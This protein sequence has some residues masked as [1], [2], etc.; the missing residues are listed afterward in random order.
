MS[1]MK[2]S[3]IDVCLFCI[4]TANTLHTKQPQSL[5]RKDADTAD[6]DTD[7]NLGVT[8][9]A[10]AARRHNDEYLFNEQLTYEYV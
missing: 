10:A 2:A 7:F 9:A 3:N 5:I 1:T 8:I 6:T 4:L